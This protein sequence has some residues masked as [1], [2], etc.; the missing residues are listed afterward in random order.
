MDSFFGN[1]SHGQGF[2]PLQTGMERQTLQNINTSNSSQQ[3]S[4]ETL[5]QLQPG[6]TFQGEI[7]SVSGQDV[8][9]Q[10]ANGQYMAAR[11]EGEVQ[12][13]LGQLLNFQVQSNKD[14]K[15]ILKPVYT[16]LLQQ[17]VGEAALKAANLAVNGKNLQLVAKLIENGMPIDKASLAVMNRQLLQHPQVKAESLIRLHQL[18][19]KITDENLTQ[20]SHYQNMEHQLL[21]GMKEAVD[22]ITK[23]Y[24]AI[25]GEG[26]E[27]SI[28][29]ADVP[30][31]GLQKADAY[32]AKIWNVLTEEKP[33]KVTAS[34]EQQLP[35]KESENESESRAE[36]SF[37][38]AAVSDK[39]TMK[40]S[41]VMKQLQETPKEQAADKLQ[42][43]I[44]QGELSADT[45]KKLLFSEQGIGG[46]LPL[47]SRDK[48]YRSEEFKNLLKDTLQNQWSLQPEELTE[49]GKIKEFYQKLLN[50]SQK[51]TQIMEQAASQSHTNTGNAMSNIRDNVEFM[52]QMN[53]MFQYV[54]LPLKLSEEHAQG[55]LYVYTNKHNLAK[56]EGTLTAIL[57]LDM[58]YL[59]SMD[60]TVSLNIDKEQVTNKFYLE[61]DSI[62]LLEEHL[63]ELTRRLVKKGYQSTT[64]LEKRVS[65]KTVFE[66]MEEQAGAGVSTLAYQKFDMRT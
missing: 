50:Q 25:A 32:M 21:D 43:L 64:F 9:L 46:R 63:E 60:I 33:E 23:L 53:Q 17:K 22:D 30:N 14:A 61:E 37:D 15:I 13:A 39:K 59:G 28:P 2:S 6:D 19:I 7:I 62:R 55:E 48:L 45:L 66:Q 24:E 4:S 16:N 27:T 8:Q 56:R 12:L 51:L 42:N 1:L 52:N 54:Q 35:L 57:H 47:E 65:E 3:V 38:E 29:A 36:P 11:L 40:F 34:E 5:L 31:D 10:L 49:E 18:G 58:D 41:E 26:S 44:T 20:L